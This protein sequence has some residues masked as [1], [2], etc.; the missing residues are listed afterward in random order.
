MLV[1]YF[2]FREEYKHVKRLGD[3]LSEIDLLINW[4]AFLPIVTGLY[5]K[6]DSFFS[7]MKRMSS[8]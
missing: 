4:E 1:I 5:P 6:F 3:K 8:L 2:A 7:F